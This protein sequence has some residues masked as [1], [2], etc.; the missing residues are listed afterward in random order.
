M[1]AR[2]LTIAVIVAVPLT[3]KALRDI[4]VA[5]NRERS[6]A[7]LAASGAPINLEP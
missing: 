2:I 5:R 4:A 1:R 3:V 7:I 6:E